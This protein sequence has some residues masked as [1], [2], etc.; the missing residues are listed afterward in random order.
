MH[1]DFAQCKQ[2]GHACRSCLSADRQ[3]GFS[4]LV[5]IFGISIV[6]LLAVVIYIGGL[7]YTV[8][9]TYKITQEF[10]EPNAAS[11]AQPSSAKDNETANQSNPVPSGNW[12]TYTNNQRGYEIKYP[13]GY[14]LKETLG[15]KTTIESVSLGKDIERIIGG[16]Q[17][18]GDVLRKGVDISFIA[19]SNKKL[20]DMD[21]SYYGDNVQTKTVVI[22]KRE[23]KEIIFTSPSN[24]KR[25]IY[26]EMPD[27]ILRI[28]FNTGFDSTV[29]LN[30][31]YQKD[32]N[33][34]LATFKFSK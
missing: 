13:N 22:D 17:A 16:G 32:F 20:S 4:A 12:K 3:A 10:N 19:I 8:N 15:S 29:E 14:E 30:V 18:G 2:K 1:F 34:I 27:Y 25:D 11:S 9:K 26:L 6:I 7:I 28:S 33:K 23:G 31:S 5:L 21:F 24:G